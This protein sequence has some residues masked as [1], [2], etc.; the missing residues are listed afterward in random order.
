MA[1]QSTVINISWWSTAAPPSRWDKG[2]RDIILKFWDSLWVRDASVLYIAFIS[3]T[4]ATERTDASPL[5]M[6]F[7]EPPSD[8]ETKD[9]RNIR[10]CSCCTLRD[11]SLIMGRG[12]YKMGKSRVRNFLR[13]PLKTG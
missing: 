3:N 9:R 11:G 4:K 2:C 7:G 8:I 6:V 5:C 10:D 12:G 1:L 13:P